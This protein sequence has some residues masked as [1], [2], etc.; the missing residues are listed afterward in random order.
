M[1][2]KLLAA[3]IVARLKR[4]VVTGLKVIVII[5]MCDLEMYMG[6]HQKND[7]ISNCHIH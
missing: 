4:I 1:L 2:V 7:C 6:E 3:E 5:S